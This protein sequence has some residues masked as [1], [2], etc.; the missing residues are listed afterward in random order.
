VTDTE[1]GGAAVTAI[2]ALA[3]LVASDT[4]VAVRETEAGAG[5]LA[6]AV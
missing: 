5:T 1:I 2:V 6:G 4:E 3:D